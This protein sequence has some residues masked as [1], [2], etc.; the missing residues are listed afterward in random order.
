M[1]NFRYHVVSL[2]AVFLALAVGVALGVAFVD[3]DDA[4][5]GGGD[6]RADAAEQA[7]EN[8]FADASSGLVGQGLTDRRVVVVTTPGA[9]SSEVDDLTARISDAGGT[10]VGEVTLT[11]KLLDSA[12]RQFAEQIAEQSAAD[13]PGVQSGDDSYS[14]IGAALAR[15]LTGDPELD[16][17]ASTIRSAFEQGGLID[18]PSAPTQRADLALVVIGP[19]SADSARGE[20]LAAVTS[21][22]STSGAGAAL[23]GPSTT[24]VDGGVLDQV[25][26]SDGAGSFSTVDVTDLAA[27]RLVSVLALVRSAAGQNG[28]WGTTRSADG[29]LPQ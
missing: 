16:E 7:F 11:T 28:S 23:V 29:Q 9:R 21:Q 14:R 27:G 15:A 10:V 12:N 20:I 22:L 4:G 26:S 3:S 2:A 8:A 19:T 6:S 18:L 17:Q 1:I 13:V 25:R 24:S 5:A